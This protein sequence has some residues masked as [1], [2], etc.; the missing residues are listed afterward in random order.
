MSRPKAR[1]DLFS[2]FKGKENTQNIFDQVETWYFIVYDC[3]TLNRRHPSGNKFAY[4]PMVFTNK[5]WCLLQAEE[6][7]EHGIPVN[8]VEVPAN[9]IVYTGK[10]IL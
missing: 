2:I 9:E 3:K 10:K 5:G 8:V 1:T 4:K 6:L 7:R